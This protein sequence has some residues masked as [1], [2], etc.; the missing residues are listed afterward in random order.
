VGSVLDRETTA[1]GSTKPW[2]ADCWWCRASQPVL[3]ALPATCGRRIANPPQ[4][5]NLP[6]K[7]VW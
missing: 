3:A 1:A 2:S 6:H 5:G 4:V 7:R